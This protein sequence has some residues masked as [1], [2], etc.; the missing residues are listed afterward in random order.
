MYINI[1]GYYNKTGVWM[2]DLSLDVYSA[3]VSE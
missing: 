2:E 1:F 3:S